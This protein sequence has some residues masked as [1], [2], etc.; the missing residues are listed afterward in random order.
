VDDAF[1]DNWVTQLRKGMLELCILNSIN[2][3]RVYGYDIVKSLRGTD[4]LVISEG[5]IYP[6]LSR[7]HREGF[8]TTDLKESTSGPPRKY[9]ELTP[10]G[11]QQL[12][13]MNAYWLTIETGIDGLRKGVEP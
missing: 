4:G 11:R 3:G 7:L 2:G 10:A 8:V 12:A 5:T 1:F 13:R 9:Y 6:I